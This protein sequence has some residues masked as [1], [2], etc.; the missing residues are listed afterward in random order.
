L[1]RKA[2]AAAQLMPR[3]MRSVVRNVDAPAARAAASRG[4]SG[5]RSS[6]GVLACNGKRCWHAQVDSL[7]I[8]KCL[9]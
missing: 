6:R 5:M 2:T 3:L 8:E 9:A 4:C 7:V 1:S